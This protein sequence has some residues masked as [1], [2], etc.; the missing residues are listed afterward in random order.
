MT[1]LKHSLAALIACTAFS[2][3]ASNHDRT[4]NPIGTGAHRVACSNVAQD[5]ALIAQYGTPPEDFWEGKP[6]NGQ[7]RYISQILASPTTAVRFD[8]VVPNGGQFP[9]YGGTAVPHVG[10]VCFPTPATNTDPDYVLPQTGDRVPHMQPASTAPKLAPGRFPFIVFSHGLGGSPIS[11]NYIDAMVELA[12]HGYVVGA[13]FHGDARFSRIRLENL[14]DV[15]FLLTRFDEFVEMELMRPLA[16]SALI[17]H[18]LAHPGFASAIDASRIGGFG[19][20]LGGQALANTMG[21]KLSQSLSRACRDTHKDPRIRATVGL[22]PYMGQSFMPAFCDDQQGVESMTNPYM[23]IAGTADT[24]APIGL[25]REA[26]NRFGGSRYL[27]EL[28]G[29]QHEYRQ[30]MRADVFTWTVAFLN[31]YLGVESDP[32]AM[33]RLIRMLTVTGGTGD[34][35]TIDRH[36]PF[37]LTNGETLVVEFY[38]PGLDHYFITGNPAEAEWV[39]GGGAGAWE[40]T[41]STFKAWLTSPPADAGTSPVCRFYGAYAGGPNSHFYTA[42]AAEC[43]WLRVVGGWWYEGTAFHIRPDASGA[44][45]D[46]LI[47]VDRAYNNGFVRNDSNHRFTTSASEMRETIRD[48][49]S[50]NGTVMCSR[51]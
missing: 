21:A 9:Q 35:L 20:S 4:V 49:W 17:D 18:L 40:A 5:P 42:N 30:D 22:V 24:T 51:P 2:A 11:P 43:A 12:S 48:G 25:T 6:A 19:I 1:I 3:A 38:H 14:D 34:M 39:R 50:P 8:V 47:A 46:G 27:V 41:G 13:A 31:A 37:A 28:E 15:T 26:V 36:V 44:C 7:L 32:T 16:I 10:I 23:A 45:P 29:V 33:A